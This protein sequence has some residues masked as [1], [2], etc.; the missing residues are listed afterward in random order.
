MRCGHRKG[1]SS[2]SNK[3]T[4]ADCLILIGLMSCLLPENLG[5]LEI[6]GPVRSNLLHTH[7]D[8][9]ALGFSY[10]NRLVFGFGPGRL[11]ASQCPRPWSPRETLGTAHVMPRHVGL[12]PVH[13][14]CWHLNTD[15]GHRPMVRIINGHY[16]NKDL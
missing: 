12:G 8:G 7:R 13:L 11:A 15:I 6:G 9:P 4:W 14:H 2:T 16:Y 3:E 10:S 1:K 5:P